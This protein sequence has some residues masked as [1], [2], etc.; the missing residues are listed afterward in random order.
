MTAG[1][2]SLKTPAQY[3]D[4]RISDEAE[5]DSGGNRKCERHGKSSDDRWRILRHVLPVDFSQSSRHDAG[6]E[7]KSGCCGI[8]GNRGRERRKHDCRNEEN[9]NRDGRQSRAS[10]RIHA[11]G[12]LDITRRGRRPDRGP[13][14]RGDGVG[15]QCL[16]DARQFTLFI[17][18]TGPMCDAD[19][20]AC[21]VE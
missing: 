11:R 12:T 13:G 10:A 4:C 21:R 2:A 20:G 1:E 8:S 17:E 3:L 14:D 18:K 16:A 9:A 5:P 7:K 19:E 15:D 6:D